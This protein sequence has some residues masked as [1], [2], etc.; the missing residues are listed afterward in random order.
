MTL[1]ITTTSASPAISNPTPKMTLEDSIDRMIEVLTSKNYTF[2]A[3]DVTKLLREAVNLKTLDLDGLPRDFAVHIGP[4]SKLTSEVD[5]TEVKDQ[6]HQIF[7]T[8]GMLN[9]TR[10]KKKSNR[11]KK[12]Y[13]EYTP[14]KNALP[15]PSGITALAN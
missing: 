3:H 12:D 13:F 2:S 10:E 11:A 15:A 8:G 14:D 9:Y 7:L 6:V 4:I 5:H 1:P